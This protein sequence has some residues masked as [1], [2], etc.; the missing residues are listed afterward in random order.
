MQTLTQ[1]IIAGRRLG[2]QDD[3]TPL[4][5][6]G[7]EEL[8][9]GA[10]QIRQALCGTEA[11]LC[12][13]INGRGGRCSEDC[14]FCA[15]SCRYET[16]AGTWDFLPQE[17]IL[18][19][20]RSNET[21][22]VHRFSIVTAGRGLV[23]ADLDR[24]VAAYE[25]LHQTCGMGLCASHGL[26]TLEDF[27]RLKAA[28]VARYHANLETSRN[29]F[30]HI[31]TTH[32]YDDKLKNIALARQAGL[33]IC[34]G[35]ILGMGESW[36]DRIDMAL[37]LQG[38]GVGSIPLNLLQPIPGTPLGEVAPLGREEALRCVALFRYLVPQA[39]IR[40]AAGRGLFPDGGR[41]L[42]RAGANAAITGDMLTTTG[43][44][45]AADRAMLM[46]LGFRLDR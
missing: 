22:G 2:A 1:E 25:T 7:L 6:A 3:L 28:G 10:D 27:Q 4:L 20:A 9:A 8:M 43:T 24:A 11:D 32:S 36:Q 39:Q 16:G 14:T 15:Q 12:T 45:I 31:C 30:P 23:G 41:D 5:T 17:E 44:G 19:C 29:Y 42:F 33:E 34:S 35:G 46:E 37:E 18:A 21:A 26:Q 40:M 13:I 38:L